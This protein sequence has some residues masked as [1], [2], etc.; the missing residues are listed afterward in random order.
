MATVYY[1]DRCA[2]CKRFMDGV[3]RCPAL[4]QSVQTVN[5]DVSPV[6]NLQYVPT[7]VLASGAMYVG[8]QA[9][10]W[11]KKYGGNVDATL[12]PYSACGGLE[13]SEFGGDGCIQF[14]QPFTNFNDAFGPPVQKM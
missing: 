8:T 14:L 1:S 3:K 10:E 11:L 6:Q 12:E 13:F 9:F 7:V 5:I 4:S 2:N